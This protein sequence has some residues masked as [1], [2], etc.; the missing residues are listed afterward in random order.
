MASDNVMVGRVRPDTR[1]EQ[2][3]I[4]TSLIGAR[5]GEGA[6]EHHLRSFRSVLKLRASPIC[7]V[8]ISTL[9]YLSEAALR[10]FGA[11]EHFVPI[12]RAL[13]ASQRAR[14][15]RHHRTSSRDC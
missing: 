3:V 12:V 10:S 5:L 9:N 2:S 13:Q 14:S 11:G 1:R 6:D 15:G 7:K 8:S 4:S